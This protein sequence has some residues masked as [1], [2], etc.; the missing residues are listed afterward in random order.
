VSAHAIYAPSSAS[1]W[2]E[3]TAS[4]EAVARLRT[5]WPEQEGEEAQEGTGAHN[6]I[7]RLL[8][9]MNGLVKPERF[10]RPVENPD[11]PAAKGI[12]LVLSY[13]EQLPVGRVWIEQ[14]VE[15]TK[16]IWGRCDVAHFHEPDAVLTIIDYKNGFLDVQAERNSQLRIYAAGSIYTHNLPA[17]WVRYVVVQPNS[18]VPGPRVKQWIE[19]ADDLFAWA[20]KTAGIPAGPKEFKAGKQCTYCPLFGL[21]QASKDVLAQLSV[22]VAKRPEDVPAEQLAVF[23]ATKKPIEHWFKALDKHGT[24][25]ALK[26]PVPGMKVIETTKHRAW[27]DEAEARK[28]IIDR[29]GVDALD[30]PTPAKVEELGMDVSSLAHKPKGG[31]ALAFAN[32]KR[33]E[34]KQTSA[35]E[36]FAAV[37]N[38]GGK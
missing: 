29:F 25:L 36:M 17:K 3:C 34:W 28:E 22:M 16:D 24:A 32:D 15:L 27:K 33:P 31:P 6:E 38:G 7:D 4:A 5:V 12:A 19:S 37:I 13:V 2:T 26:G 14:R 8:G 10:A 35:A 11:H 9:H 21:C 30:L 20:S 1:V 23:L 18:I